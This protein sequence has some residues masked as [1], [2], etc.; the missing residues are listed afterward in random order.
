[1]LADLKVIILCECWDR[2]Q[3]IIRATQGPEGSAR[4][5]QAKKIQ[6]LLLNDR[7]DRIDIMSHAIESL[8]KRLAESTGKHWVQQGLHVFTQGLTNGNGEHADTLKYR[9]LVCSHPVTSVTYELRG[10]QGSIKGPIRLNTQAFS[11]ENNDPIKVWRDSAAHRVCDFSNRN[12]CGIP[13][14]IPFE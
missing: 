1:M 10:S 2:R 6:E 9:S 11:H 3:L 8:Y 14:L 5:H 4:E 12:E 13:F 7:F